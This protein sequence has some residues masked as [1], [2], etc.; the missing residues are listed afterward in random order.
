M[1]HSYVSRMYLS[2]GPMIKHQV[3]Y[4]FMY[5]FS[6]NAPFFNVFCMHR[7][8]LEVD[9]M[10]DRSTLL[11]MLVI[12]KPMEGY[13][14]MWKEQLDSRA[15][16]ARRTAEVLER[17]SSEVPGGYVDVDKVRSVVF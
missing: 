6:Q 15:W 1:T 5:S 13:L 8:M 11:N 3:T 16:V 4:I 10:A 17:G 2:K 7:S 12:S 9:V 14:L